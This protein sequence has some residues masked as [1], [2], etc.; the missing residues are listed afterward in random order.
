MKKNVFVGV[1]RSISSASGEPPE[2]SPLKFRRKLPDRSPMRAGK[3][4]TCNVH[5]IVSVS[6]EPPEESPP[7]V[8][9]KLPALLPKKA[10]QASPCDEVPSESEG[11][12]TKVIPQPAEPWDKLRGDQFDVIDNESTLDELSPTLP[13]CIWGQIAAL[14]LERVKGQFL[15]SEVLPCL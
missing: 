12:D 9:R 5:S 4:S 13:L 1:M 8:R 15:A 14:L 3:E 7:K 2:E 6:G 11:A 10:S